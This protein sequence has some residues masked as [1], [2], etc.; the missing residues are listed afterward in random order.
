M[1][2]LLS[3]LIAFPS[4]ATD[5]YLPSLPQLQS[6]WGASMGQVNLSLI[7][8]FA[9]CTSMMLVYGPVSD[10]FG[11][12]PVLY[13][14]LSLF[15]AGSLCCAA[16][17]GLVWLVVARTVQ[18]IGA[19]SA[20][21][22]SIAITRDLYEGVQRQRVLGY[23]GVIF[24]VCPMVA[25]TVGGWMLV[26]ASWRWIFLAQAAAAAVALGCVLFLKEPLQERTRGGVLALAG[27]YLHLLRNRD[28][29]AL[30]G[31]FAAM[32]LP[33]FSFIGGAADIYVNR[34]GVSEQ[35]F[36][37]YFGINASGMMI[38]SLLCTR[39]AGTI[40]DSKLLNSSLVGMV[41]AAL[42]LAFL[43][44]RSP[45]ALTAV[46]LANSICMGLNRPISNNMILDT[47]NQDYGA[48]S[49]LMMFLF[50]MVGVA[51]MAF[52]SLDW[53]NKVAVLNVMMGVGSLLPLSVL[54]ARRLR[55]RRR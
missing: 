11:R 46:M 15:I 12:K 16:A 31:T 49:A 48:A 23:I 43:G 26:V 55:L 20:N 4:M 41:A 14:G 40:S 45:L 30:V 44:G 22:M 37:V 5:M 3:L 25:P 34:F 54:A 28:Y 33:L 42:S 7:C 32:M 38:G 29:M 24:S 47:V 6:I 19:A 36:G 35:M 51:A 50:S 8:F 21:T 18:G 1:T 13:C 53:P 39:L 17:D 27:R 9:A 10:R 52:I 2:L